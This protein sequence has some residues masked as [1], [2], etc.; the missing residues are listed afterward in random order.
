MKNIPKRARLR[1]NILRKSN[2]IKT[3]KNANI[4]NI[5]TDLLQAVENGIWEQ[6]VDEVVRLAMLYG[7]SIDYIATELT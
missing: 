7:V 6:P 1:K 5:D 3:D 4:P 2:I